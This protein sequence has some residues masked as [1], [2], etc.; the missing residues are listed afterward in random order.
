MV[1]PSHC[2][3]SPRRALWDLLWLGPMTLAVLLIHGFH[4]WAEDGG[5]YVAGVEYLLRP[6]L[7]PKE[8]AFV[9]EHLRFSLFGP[10][11]AET[12]RLTHLSLAAVL[13][14]AYLLSA[15][16]NVFAALRI[17]KLCFNT[18]GAQW[19]AVG[20]LAVWWTL[21]VAGTSLLL[22]DPYV[23]AR[24]FSTPF[25]LLAVAS[26]MRWKPAARG[27]QG[28]PAVRS[29]F[30]C[31]LLLAAAAAMHPLMAG[32]AF[33][34][35][36]VLLCQKALGDRYVL[37][38]ALLAFAGAGVMQALSRPE[39]PAVLE[40]AYSRYYWF[41]SRWQ[42]YEWL[43]LLFPMA[44]LLT[45]IRTRPSF[46]SGEAIQLCRAAVFQAAGAVAIAACFAR[47]HLVAHT[48]ARLQ[49]LRAFLLLYA[50]MAMML[51]GLMVEGA[52]RMERSLS[53]TL[54][55]GLVRCTPVLLLVLLGWIMFRVQRAEFAL[56]PHVELPGR[57]NS[58][59]WF[60][61]FVW[62]RKYT[63]PDALFALDAR[64]VNTDG[65]DAQTFR[66]IAERSAIPDYSKDGG[67]AAITPAL[68]NEWQRSAA[69]THN[70]NQ[71][72]DVVR[73]TQLRPFHVQWMILDANTP[74]GHPCSYRNATVKVC[75]V[76]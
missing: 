19:S 36:A 33:A 55:Q 59:P 61:A 9:T 21:P 20:T 8:T 54:L 60:E 42:W 27:P 74:T 65:E 51:G 57:V 62:S 53:G 76:N 28:A 26:A 1:T 11:L 52:R 31:V 3:V 73:D 29:L 41:L 70:L 37:I 56:S 32:Y 44:I 15:F 64:Y 24:S 34:L 5:L 49:P 4:P 38:L 72:S 40:A 39:S 63:S 45:I 23:T 47:V 58:N 75:S 14:A 16:L 35:V 25:S 18:R 48:I 2:T 68:A 46:L 22:M 17:A 10:A 30:S 67:E 69:A 66:S 7:F 13:L 12:V 6:T 71:L 50:L 43:G